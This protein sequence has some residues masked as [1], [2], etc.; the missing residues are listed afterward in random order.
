M[1]MK[2]YVS[3][4]ILTILLSM[5]VSCDG[6]LEP[7][8]IAS[9][10]YIK[11]RIH[12]KGNWS[13]KDSIFDLRAIAFKNFPPANLLTEIMSGQAYFLQDSLPYYVDSSDFILEIPDPPVTL[14]YIAIA[15]RYGDLFSWRAVGVYTISGNQTENASINVEAGKTYNIDIN[16]DFNNMP[17][18][19][20]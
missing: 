8:P 16:V 13:P 15:Q 14:K 20:F 6:G 2:R 12:Y 3:A 9:K 7:T 18:Q 1:K 17:P 5:L 11:G 10:A 4:L 19:P